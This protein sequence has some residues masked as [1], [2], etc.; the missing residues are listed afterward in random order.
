MPTIHP[1]SLAFVV[2]ALRFAHPTLCDHLETDLALSPNIRGSLFMAVGM[3]SFTM[4]DAITKAVSS[5]MNFG[6]LR[7]PTF[8]AAAVIGFA[9]ARRATRISPRWHRELPSPPRPAESEAG[10]PPRGPVSIRPVVARRA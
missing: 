6:A 1:G 2:G 4:N 5:E 9:P 10:V 8:S 3:A 7:G